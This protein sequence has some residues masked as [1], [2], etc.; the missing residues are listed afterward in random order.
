M[1]HVVIFISGCFFGAM[2]AYLDVLLHVLKYS[3]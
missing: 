2:V 3:K 1:D